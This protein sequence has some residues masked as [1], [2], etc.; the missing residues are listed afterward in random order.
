MSESQELYVSVNYIKHKVD[1]IEK[2]ELLN[3]SSN[4]DLRDKYVLALQSD[5]LLFEVYKA[6]DGVKNQKEI[7]TVVSTTEMTVSRKISILAE[8][9]LIEIIDIKD[10]KKIYKYSIA[11]QAFKLTKIKE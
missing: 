11:E 8:L 10:H 5:L 2:I 1:A 9:G 4:K 3:L 7:A 6:I